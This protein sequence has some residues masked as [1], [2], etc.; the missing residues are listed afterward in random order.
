MTGWEELNSGLGKTYIS[1]VCLTCGPGVTLYNKEIYDKGFTQ[2][3]LSQ[4]CTVPSKGQVGCQVHYTKMV[5]R[6]FGDMGCM[7]CDTRIGYY[8]FKNWKTNFDDS[9]CKKAI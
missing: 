2:K 4:V 1:P 9:P 5:E 3:V 7:Q 6:E 8:A